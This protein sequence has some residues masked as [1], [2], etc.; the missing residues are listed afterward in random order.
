MKVLIEMSIF[1]PQTLA[2]RYDDK[3]TKAR[4]YEK[5]NDPSLFFL[6]DS[7]FLKILKSYS[8]NIKITRSSYIELLRN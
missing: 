8:A 2:G 6:N 3:I 4:E 7:H 1:I 5:S